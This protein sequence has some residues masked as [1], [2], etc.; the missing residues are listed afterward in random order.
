MVSIVKDDLKEIVSTGVAAS[1][2]PPAGQKPRETFADIAARSVA[3]AVA[4]KRSVV[5]IRP[6]SVEGTS[7]ECTRST[8]KSVL[9]P[10]EDGFRVAKVRKARGAGVIVET[11][12]EEGV[13]RIMSFSERL[14][15]KG[16]KAELPKGRK[17]QIVVYDVPRELKDEDFLQEIFDSNLKDHGFDKENFMASAKCARKFGPRAR[18]SVG[19]IITCSPQ[20]R[21]FLTEQGYLCLQWLSCKVRDYVG[22]TRCFKCHLYGHTRGECKSQVQVCSRCAG[23]GHERDKCQAPAGRIVCATC[24]R[25]NKRADHPTGDRDCPFNRAAIERVAQSTSYE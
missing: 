8:L 11:T 20:V 5:V 1:A 2:V 18:N 15:Q 10:V 17:P 7:A 16:L 13:E 19:H 22:A 23:K 24:T 6:E 9:N 25:F 14:K 3:K 12:T 21:K 4:A